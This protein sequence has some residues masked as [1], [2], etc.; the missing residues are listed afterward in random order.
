MEVFEEDGINYVNVNTESSEGIKRAKSLKL[1]QSGLAATV[2]SSRLNEIT[3]IFSI[4]HRARAFTLL[5]HVS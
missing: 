3:S 2:F 5:R 4:D 1:I